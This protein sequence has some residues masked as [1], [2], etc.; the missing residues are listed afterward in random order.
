MKVPAGHLYVSRLV[1]GRSE[2]HHLSLIS[3]NV[4]LHMAYLIPRNYIVIKQGIQ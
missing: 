2:Y 4:Y 3:E 1:L